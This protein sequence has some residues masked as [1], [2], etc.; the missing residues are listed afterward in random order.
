M[1][2]CRQRVQMA[3]KLASSSGLVSLVIVVV[4]GLKRKMTFY[5]HVR[6]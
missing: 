2:T 1:Q 6:V 5:V 3:F 4:V